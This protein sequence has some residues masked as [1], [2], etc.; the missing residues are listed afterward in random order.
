M[1]T[2]QT[3]G[4]SWMRRMKTKFLMTRPKS[5]QG[6]I[7]F[8]RSVNKIVITIDKSSRFSLQ[9]LGQW[10]RQKYKR[11][12]T[13]SASSTGSVNPFISVLDAIKGKPPQKLSPFHQYFKLHYKSRI[14][15]E[16]IRRF[17][18]AKEEYE[19]TTEQE[20]REKK[21]VCTGCHCSQKQ[22][23]QRILAAGVRRIPSRGRRTRR[24]A[25]YLGYGKMGG[26]SANVEDASA[27]PSVSVISF[28][29]V[30]NLPCS[31]R[32]LAFAAQYVQP[33]AKSI[34]EHMQAA[35][36]ILIIGPCP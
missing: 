15:A 32:Q 30:T 34:S 9:K 10:Y 17:N 25:T 33:V 31:N 2:H 18:W 4:T 7:K 26:I 35:V 20:R 21:V 24:K 13:G 11:L 23:W 8:G 12:E 6:T 16:Y 1:K 3:L 27:I 36:S 22:G 28:I 19:N 29:I 5:G 14:R